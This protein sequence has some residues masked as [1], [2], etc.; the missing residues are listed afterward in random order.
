[1][2]ESQAVIDVFAFW[3]GVELHVPAGLAG[4]SRGNANSG[5]RG[6]QD[7]ECW[8]GRTKAPDHPRAGRNGRRGDIQLRSV[9]PSA[10]IYHRHRSWHLSN[11]MSSYACV[12][13][14]CSPSS[15]TFATTSAGGVSSGTWKLTPGPCVAGNETPRDAPH[16]WIADPK[17][18]RGRRIRTGSVDCHSRPSGS[19]GVATR[20]EVTRRG[21]N[22]RCKISLEPQVEGPSPV[23]L[24]P[25]GGYSPT[26]A[27]CRVDP[28]QTCVGGGIRPRA[29]R[30]A[31][32]RP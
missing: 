22:C 8:G 21:S 17:R 6:G 15:A 30:D 18:E 12:V 2:K 9:P 5:R 19:R 4:A 31:A 32:K 13:Q 7:P 11:E 23:L 25:S 28:A 24:S 14:R 10:T 20:R 16:S 27:C 26:S 1:M 3:G 29:R